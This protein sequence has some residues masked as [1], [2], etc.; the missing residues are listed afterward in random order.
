M[1]I[2]AG[3]TGSAQEVITSFGRVIARQ[4]YQANI[5]D[6][7]GD[8][9]FKT[10]KYTTASGDTG[11][12]ALWIDSDNSYNIKYTDEA[13]GDTTNDPSTFTNPSYFFDSNDSTAATKSGS[14]G[15]STTDYYLGKTFSSKYIGIVKIKT[16]SAVTDATG[17]GSISVKLQTYD[18]ADWSDLTTLGSLGSLGTNTISINGYYL[19]NSSVQGIR[20]KSTINPDNGSWSLA[21]YTLEYGNYDSS[22]IVKENSVFSKNPDSIVVYANKLTPTNTSITFDVSDDGGSNYPITNQVFDTYV[23]T[24]ILTGTSIGLKFNLATTDTSVTPKLYGWSAV[25]MDD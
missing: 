19:I 7:S 9:Y 3:Q 5:S 13:S 2:K 21:Y 23:D 18:G 17:G 10:E 22:S 15:V 25:I 16:A 24:T 14:G 1:V 4:A 12:T 11:T 6:A 20:I 8:E